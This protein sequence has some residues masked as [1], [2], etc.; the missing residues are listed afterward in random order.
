[1]HSLSINNP[2]VIDKRHIVKR[3]R[4]MERA[5]IR[6]DRPSPEAVPPTDT[7]LTEIRAEL[8]ASRFGGSTSTGHL[9]LDSSDSAAC[10][11]RALEG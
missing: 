5:G 8:G 1:M 7:S 11:A 4:T 2:E 10:V 6:Y 9:S 3:K